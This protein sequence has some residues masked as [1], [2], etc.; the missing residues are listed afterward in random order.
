MSPQP[1][2]GTGTQMYR[3][4]N[5]S[6]TDP[7]CDSQ[8]MKSTALPRAAVSASC[9]FVHFVLPRFRASDRFTGIVRHESYDAP[10][11][12]VCQPRLMSLRC[13]KAGFLAVS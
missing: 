8:S 1:Q 11:K 7:S 6:I 10:V 9:C 13:P 5:R 4:V 3:L 12:I 2:F